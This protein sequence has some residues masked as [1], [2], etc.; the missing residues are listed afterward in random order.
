MKLR[1]ML[2]NIEHVG[3]M[4][5]NIELRDYIIYRSLTIYGT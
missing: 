1:K 4:Q 2:F 5:Q 3:E